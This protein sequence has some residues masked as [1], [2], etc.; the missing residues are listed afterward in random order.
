MSNFTDWAAD[1]FIRSARE[2]GCMPDLLRCLSEDTEEQW[3]DRVIGEIDDLSLSF[4][5]INNEALYIES[6]REEAVLI[7]RKLKELLA[8]ELLKLANSSAAP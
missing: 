7:Y 5:I 2:M 8:P 1:R 6:Q 4:V 3:S